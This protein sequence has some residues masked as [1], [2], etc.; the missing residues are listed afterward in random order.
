[1][2]QRKDNLVAVVSK[3]PPTGCKVVIT[4]TPRRDAA[5]M[6]ELSY[7]GDLVA[8]CLSAKRLSDWAFEQGAQV[9]THS[10][11]LSLSDGEA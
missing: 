11:N 1:M 7:N 8:R 2:I 9:V 5:A 3:F 10:Y 6:F 4:A